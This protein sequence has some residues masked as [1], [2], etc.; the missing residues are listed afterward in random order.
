MKS[1]FNVGYYNHLYHVA[2][3]L[4]GR[5]QGSSTI[6]TFSFIKNIPNKFYKQQAGRYEAR[7]YGENRYGDG[8]GR[9]NLVPV[10]PH[11]HNTSWVKLL[12]KS[13][14]EILLTCHPLIPTKPTSKILFP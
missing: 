10:S 12:T 11:I 5:G 13:I 8:D 4:S 9:V 7:D 3:L 1:K 2:F 14:H 6:F